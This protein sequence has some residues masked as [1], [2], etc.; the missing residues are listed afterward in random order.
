M[1]SVDAADD[2][3]S[4]VDSFFSLLS[5]TVLTS[6]PLSHGKSVMMVP[7]L[8]FAAAVVVTGVTVKVNGIEVIESGMASEDTVTGTAV[9]GTRFAVVAAVVPP[10]SVLSAEPL[11]PAAAGRTRTVLAPR[12]PAL[13]SVELL[14]SASSKLVPSLVKVVTGG[15][16]R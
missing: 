1:L 13:P 16:K 7:A 12:V 4:E 5:V 2:D 8:P 11:G 15:E 9:A 6:T 3:G 10:L 14:L